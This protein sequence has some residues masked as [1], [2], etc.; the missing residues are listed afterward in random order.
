MIYHF[1][2]QYINKVYRALR[3]HNFGC[4]KP[5]KASSYNIPHQMSIS[6]QTKL[7]N[8]HC[9]NQLHR[10]KGSPLV[11]FYQRT[12]RPTSTLRGREDGSGDVEKP[13]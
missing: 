4:Y 5:G 6:T 12:D 7:A 1:Y 8:L 11:F 2:G 3:I 9:S 10:M 13:T